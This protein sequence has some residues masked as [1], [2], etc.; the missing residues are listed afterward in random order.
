MKNDKIREKKETDINSHSGEWV[1]PEIEIL[2]LPLLAKQCYWRLWQKEF[3]GFTQCHRHSCSVVELS[4]ALQQPHSTD[5]FDYTL[6]CRK[7]TFTD[8][9][10]K[11]VPTTHYSLRTQNTHCEW[12]LC[13]FQRDMLPLRVCFFFTGDGRLVQRYP[14]GQVPL[15][16]GGLSWSKWWGGEDDWSNHTTHWYGAC[17]WEKNC[18]SIPKPRMGHQEFPLF[19]CSA[20]IDFITNIQASISII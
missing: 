18:Y 9:T 13:E 3:I 2:L 4:T 8:I 16:T 6:L 1:E 17:C 10:E 20:V 7:D 19:V 5:A 15:P 12:K 14:S 11:T